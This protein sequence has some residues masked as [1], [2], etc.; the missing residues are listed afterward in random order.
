M[1]AENND[2]RKWIYAGLA[3]ICFFLFQIIY[4]FI[5]QLG[6]WF[7]L[8]S[9]IANYMIVS[10]MLAIAL[11]ALAFVITVKNKTTSTFLAETYM[12]MTKVVFP[13]RPDTFRTTI[14]VMI[15][16]TIVGFILG[17]FDL[18]AGWVLSKLPTFY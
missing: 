6:D 10:Q 15:L 12:E 17:M 11:S 16:V 4:R 13:N 2:G 3:L 14:V 9:K 8:E 5:L 18:S 1:I 7:E